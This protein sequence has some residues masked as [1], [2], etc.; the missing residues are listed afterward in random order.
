[1][2][3]KKSLI[4]SNELDKIAIEDMEHKSKVRLGFSDYSIGLY[5]NTKNKILTELNATDEDWNNPKWQLK[6]RITAV[7][8]ISNYVGL[9]QDEYDDI[10]KVS[11]RYRFAITPYYFSLIDFNNP[12]CPIKLQSFPDIREL[13]EWGQLDPMNEGQS[14]PSGRITRRY[15][16]N[17]LLCLENTKLMFQHN[18]T[19]LAR[20][21]QR[22]LGQLTC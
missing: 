22:P 13:D 18:S 21:L 12:N 20:L 8:E 17:W 7:D 14:N 10:E 11:E 5:E 3:R 15:M 16:R 6:N 19:M 9:T 4:R 2:N 1:M